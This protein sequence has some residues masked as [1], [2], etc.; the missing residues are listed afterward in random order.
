MAAK[1]SVSKPQ[2]ESQGNDRRK[3]VFMGK[4][5]LRL[6]IWLFLCLTLVDCYWIDFSAAFEEKKEKMVPGGWSVMAS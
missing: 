5:Q 4:N 2:C 3:R 6:S 1:V